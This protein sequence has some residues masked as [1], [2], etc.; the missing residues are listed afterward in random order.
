[1]LCNKFNYVLGCNNLT[2]IV[3]RMTMGPLFDFRRVC[4]HFTIHK[5]TIE[6]YCPYK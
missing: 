4:V 6:F 5:S 2:V 1:M 3:I